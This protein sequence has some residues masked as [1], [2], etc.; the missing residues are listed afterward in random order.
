M[1][2]EMLKKAK[3]AIKSKPVPQSLEARFIENGLYDLLNGVYVRTAELFEENSSAS[4][5]LNIHLEQILPCIAFYEA[6]LK[7]TGDKEKS[8]K[9]FDEWAYDRIMKLVPPIK[10]IMALGL[11]KKVPDICDKLLG[12][13]FGS[14][15]GFESREVPDAPKFAR[16]MTVCPYFETCKKYGCPEITQFFCKSDDITYGNMHPKLVWGRTQTLG[17]GGECCDFRLYLK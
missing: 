10:R 6:L 8:L 13:F 17:T 11:Y 3:K 9:L 7:Q 1:N 12:K 15:A 2:A 4:K 14:E 16:D 5:A